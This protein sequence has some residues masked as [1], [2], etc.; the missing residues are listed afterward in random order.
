MTETWNLS[1]KQTDFLTK[2][3]AWISKEINP[4]NRTTGEK[5]ED[6]KQL[7]SRDHKL[8]GIKRKGLRTVTVIASLDGIWMQGFPTNA[9]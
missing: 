1:H 6:I 5:N 8:E 2:T 7:A 4:L 9:F 3:T